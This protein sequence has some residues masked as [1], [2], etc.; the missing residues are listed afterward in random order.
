[1]LYDSL[2]GPF[3]DF[4]FMRRAL[5]ASLAL[6]TGGAAIGVFLILR[7]MTLMGDALAH[8]LLPGAALGFVLG[9]LS[10]PAM[11]L[12]GF[13]AGIATA[14]ASGAIARFTRMRE[15]ASFG[16]AY[17]TALALGV[18]IVSFRGSAID[19]MNILFGAILAV[20]NTALCLVVGAT[21]VTLV[22]LA[23]IYRPLVVEC[24]NP[25]FLA[26]MGVRGAVYHYLFLALAVL[27]MVAA[28]QALGTLMALG[29][30]L[31]PAVAASFWAR[32][33]WSMT[34]IAAPMAFLSAAIGLLVSFHAG[35][36]SGPA[37][38]LVASLFFLGSLLFGSRASVRARLSQPA[39]LRG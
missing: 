4:A 39:H 23:A 11:S 5:V 3:A 22:G 15:D 13:A 6:S 1:M 12:G 25:G 33:V 27:N 2:I 9:G 26:A 38:V 18:M 19:L 31:L 7:R 29:L 14:L 35:L 17:L 16:A 28:F 20:D 21:T 32:E 8:A 10:L 24:F 30:M 36:P 37:I 34:A